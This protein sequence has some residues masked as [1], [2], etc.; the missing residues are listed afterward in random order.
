MNTKEKNKNF[1]NKDNNIIDIDFIIDDNS[2]INDNIN[3]IKD[4]KD[5]DNITIDD[6]NNI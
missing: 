2:N 5:I 6:I 3:K 4:K 1:I